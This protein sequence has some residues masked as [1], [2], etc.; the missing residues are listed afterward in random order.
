MKFHKNFLIYWSIIYLLIA[1]VGRFASSKKEIFP[2]FR[3]SLYSKT[4]NTLHHAYILVE[5]IG[6]S[7]LT[8]PTDIRDLYDHHHINSVNMNVIVQ[9]FYQDVKNKGDYSESNIF[10]TLSEDSTFVLYET[11]VDLSVE[12]Y[13]S[14]MI[15]NEILTFKNSNFYFE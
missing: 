1:F 13:K 5:K 9:N 10:K 8:K 15:S 12:A 4:P 11:T 6:D 7:T 2:F 3:W 14:S